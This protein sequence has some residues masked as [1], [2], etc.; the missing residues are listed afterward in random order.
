M[1]IMIVTGASSGIGREFARYADGRYRGI[2]EIWLIARRKEALDSLANSL[3]TPCKIFA[4]D[5]TDCDAISRFSDILAIASPRIR[6]LINAA[7]LGYL[8]RCDSIPLDDQ[9]H[10]ID[11]NAIALTEITTICL[12]YMHKGSRVIQMASAAAFLPQPK[13]AVYA[14]TKAYV[15]FYSKALAEEVRKKGIYITSVCPGPVDTPFFDLA[16]K[17]AAS[18]V[19]KN[20][21]R[22]SPEKVVRCAFHASKSRKSVC[23]PGF[24]MKIFHISCKML[25]H[26]LFMPILRRSL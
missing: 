16:E 12:P 7:G 5:L 19:L 17:Y 9:R 8:G 10:E 13:F 3:K 15:L 14:A 22:I 4:M 2:D 20:L 6:I 24:F 23:V 1:N 11:L 25:P 18:P 26:A 21:F